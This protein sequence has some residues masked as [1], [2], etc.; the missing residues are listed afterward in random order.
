VEALHEAILETLPELL[1]WLPWARPDHAR[2]DTR[3]YVRHARLARARRTSYEFAVCA[4]ASGRLLGVVG[5]HR[6]DW[7]RREAALGYWIRRSEWGRGFATEAGARVVEHGFRALGLNRI[8]AHV[9]PVNHRSQRVVEKLGFAREGIAREIERIGDRYVDHI[10]YSL[11]RRE[12]LGPEQL[13][14]EDTL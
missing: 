10:Q 14:P 5:L 11:L 9:A 1:R 6:L 4:S 7:S 2:S 12:V 8:E 13:E 3:R